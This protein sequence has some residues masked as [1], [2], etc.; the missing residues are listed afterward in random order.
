M[1]KDSS[2]T[3]SI[4]EIYERALVPLLF[5]PYAIDMA[6][7]A[8]ARH[9]L[10]V[11]EIAAGTGAV[12]RHLLQEIPNAQI[13]AT[14]LNPAMLEQARKAVDS[15]RVEWRQADA[16]DL[17]FPDASFD[18]VVCQF[19]VMFF[20]D[21]V[22]GFSEA[23]RVLK[24]GGLYFFNVWDG[25]GHNDFSATINHA[26]AKVFHE[27]PPRFLARV[28]Y[29]YHDVDAIREELAG[30]G[31]GSGISHEV[32]GA[33]SRADAARLAATAL[34][35][36]SPLKADIEARDASRLQEATDVATAA[37]VANFGSGAIEGKMQAIVFTCEA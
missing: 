2:F 11:L 10:R 35:Q 22:R 5:T 20:P 31:W 36:G 9:P 29:G 6:R 19:G 17:P 26:L 16:Q 21:K 32:V 24:P 25:I 18:A 15:T 23:R 3:G 28:P 30:A 1:D 33:A 4:P 7:R 34:C 13:V 37:L 12:T 14:D 8:A 27:D